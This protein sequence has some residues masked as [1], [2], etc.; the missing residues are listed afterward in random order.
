[1]SF[2]AVLRIQ[3]LFCKYKYRIFPSGSDTSCFN[4]AMERAHRTIATSVRAILFSTNLPVKF[5]PLA[6]HHKICIQNSIPYCRQSAS[7][8]FLTTSKKD[9]FTKFQT[10]SCRVHVRSSGVRSKPFKNK[11]RQGI[12]LGY[13]PSSSCVI[14]WFNESSKRV[15]FAT[16]AKFDEGFN[17]LPVDNLPINY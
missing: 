6:F 16:H 7:P 15:K 13:V 5:W 2:G 4:G 14:I 3:K 9:N 8:L 17:N 11:A 12:F 10:F 1:M